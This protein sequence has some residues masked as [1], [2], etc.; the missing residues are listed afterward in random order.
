MRKPKPTTLPHLIDLDLAIKGERENPSGA[1]SKTGT[2]ASMAIGVLLDNEKHS[3]MHDLESFFWVLFWICVHYNGPGRDIG[4]TVYERWNYEEACQLAELKMGL[5]SSEAHFLGRA[6]EKF[7][8][9]YGPLIPYVNRLRR[10]VFP[11]GEAFKIP[12]PNLYLEMIEI[13]RAAQ[14]DLKGR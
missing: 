2:R 14:D 7:T 10:K 9:Y 6:R 8:S 11:N 3:F 12:N 5:I 13:L 4:V 1:R